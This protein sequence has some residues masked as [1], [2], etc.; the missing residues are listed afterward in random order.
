MAPATIPEYAVMRSERIPWREFTAQVD[1]LCLADKRCI[2]NFI[3]YGGGVAQNDWAEQGLQKAPWQ[4]DEVPESCTAIY[5][6][7]D[8]NEKVKRRLYLKSAEY[9]MQLAILDN[10]TK[11][12]CGN[13][14]TYDQVPKGVQ[15]FEL[16]VGGASIQD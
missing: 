5:Y 1:H 16:G 8:K 4:Q 2:A 15:R 3:K 12:I 10:R 13:V 14:V 6:V 9:L 11:T 7:V